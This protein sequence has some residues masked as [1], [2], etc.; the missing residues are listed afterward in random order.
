MRAMQLSAPRTPLAL[1]SLPDPA[2]GRGEVRV[3]VAACGVCRTDLHVVD[4]E[5]PEPR[6]PLIPGHEI[7]GRVDALG[8]GVG[9]LEVGQRVGVPW[10]AHTCG[11][12]AYC[13]A[14][15]E[16]L[17]NTPRFTGYTRDGGYAT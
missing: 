17:C 6:L 10:L 11:V 5:L 16:N 8:A 9:G 15:Q 1:V 12:C 2:P 7:V 3:R 13:V 4:G 14:G